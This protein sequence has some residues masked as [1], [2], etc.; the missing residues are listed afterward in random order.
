[1]STAHRCRPLPLLS[2]AEMTTKC[3]I[4]TLT[5]RVKAGSGTN[6]DPQVC[7]CLVRPDGDKRDTFDADQ[8]DQARKL[9][10][11]SHQHC[12]RCMNCC[13][14]ALSA[15]MDTTSRPTVLAAGSTAGHCSCNC[16]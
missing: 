15:T 6:H 12:A 10:T 7:G 3:A 16:C 5:D 14:A 9:K 11:C 4:E 2:I 13:Y 1:M 8:A